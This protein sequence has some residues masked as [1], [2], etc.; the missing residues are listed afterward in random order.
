VYSNCARLQNKTFEGTEYSLCVYQHN[1]SVTC[2]NT[3]LPHCDTSL[4][5]Y[6]Y[7]HTYIR[8]G[9]YV[10]G[11]TSLCGPWPPF[12]VSKSIFRHAVELPGRII[13][14]SQGLYLHRTTQHRRIKDEHACPERNSNPRSS[15]RAFK[16]RP[17]DCVATGSAYI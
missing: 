7:T 3:R 9:M 10:T 2:I 12:F 8:V 4:Y 5:I 13:S 14:S 16:A 1:T 15:V 11:C 17:S 6:I